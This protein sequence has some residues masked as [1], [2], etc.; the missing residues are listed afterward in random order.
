[1]PSKWPDVDGSELDE[2]PK[3]TGLRYRGRWRKPLG[4]TEWVERAFGIDARRLLPL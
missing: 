1:M 4:L 2:A 3:G